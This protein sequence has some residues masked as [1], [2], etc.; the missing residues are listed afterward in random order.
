MQEIKNIEKLAR[1]ISTERIPT[2]NYARIE[3]KQN[4]KIAWGKITTKLTILGALG[5]GYFAA[6][7]KVNERM[8]EDL[9]NQFS[10][11]PWNIFES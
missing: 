9:L 8:D 5:L 6:C 10:I 1:E 11:T 2:L 7:N 3:E 4:Y